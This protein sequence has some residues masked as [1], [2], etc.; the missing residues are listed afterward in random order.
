MLT[1]TCD[2]RNPSTFFSFARTIGRLLNLAS[3]PS[4]LF[5]IRSAHCTAEATNDSVR[6]PTQKPFLNGLVG[7]FPVMSFILNHSR[8]RIFSRTLDLLARCNERRLR[9]EYFDSFQPAIDSPRLAIHQFQGA[10]D[11]PHLLFDFGH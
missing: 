11:C 4:T 2:G 3:I 5:M 1:D 7:T 8:I 10:L 9:I 6:G